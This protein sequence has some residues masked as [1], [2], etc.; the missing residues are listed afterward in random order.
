MYTVA[1]VRAA[2]IVVMLAALS[3][4]WAAAAQR[5]SLEVA[6]E[7]GGGLRATSVDDGAALEH[8]TTGG[9]GLSFAGDFRFVHRAG[10][11]VA[12]R[13]AHLST[14]LDHDD[15]LGLLAFDLAYVHRFFFTGTTPGAISVLG[16]AT[17]AFTDADWGEYCQSEG[18]IDFCGG[19]EY[20]TLPPENADEYEHEAVGAVVGGSADLLPG[21]VGLGVGAEY[22]VAFVR[23][24]N[25][26][27][28]H[29]VVT[30]RLRFLVR[31]LLD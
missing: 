28:V 26:I 16:G 30:L 25:P 29:H 31:A 3:V 11:G 15:T 17:W 18:M 1:T 24:E 6:G 10:P 8:G 27:D 22:R 21:A 12:L 19:H 20:G 23:G 9:S 13:I 14:D 4:P 5:T 7:A 2:P